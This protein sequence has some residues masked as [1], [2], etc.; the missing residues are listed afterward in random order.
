MAE[1]DTPKV[2]TQAV[3]EFM[4][5]QAINPKMAKQA[6]YKPEEQRVKRKELLREKK[7]QISRTSPKAELTKADVTSAARISRK[8]PRRTAEDMQAQTIAGDVQ[9]VAVEEGAVSRDALVTA[10]QGELTGP[11]AAQTGVAA[12]IDADLA[13]EVGAQEQIAGATAD[14]DFLQS[15]EYRAQ[16]SGFVSDVTGATMQ[17]TPDMTVEGQLARLSEQFNDGQVPSWAAGALRTAN[18]QMA[19]R[20]LG[21]SSMAGAAV[22]Q[23]AME[24]AVPIAVQDSQ[25][26]YKTAV[27]IMNNDQQARLANTQNNL[28]VDL[29]NT[30]NR[31]QM[32]L[33]K[34]QVNASLAGQELSNQQQAN[35]LNAEKFAEAAN[36]TFNFDQQREFANSKMMETMNLQNLSNKQATALAN[37][38]QMSQMDLA[39][40]N[41]RQQAAVQNAQSFMQMDMANLT[42]TQQANVINQAAYQQ[43]MLSDQAAE[44][45]A[46]QFNATSQ[47]QVDQFFANLDQ[48]I[49]KFNAAANNASSQFN[50]GQA[51]ALAQFNNTMKNQR[52]QFNATNKLAVEQ[53]NVQWRREVNTANTAAQNA[54]NQI[55]AA[56]YLNISNTAQN[57][58]WQQFRDE[59]DYAYTAAENANDRSFNMAMAILEADVNRENYQKYLDNETAQAIGDFI[60]RIGISAINA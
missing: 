27:Q 29:A 22:L 10:Q 49:K 51:N 24:A 16:Q 6:V 12:G 53:S 36:I 2:G 1:D 15:D 44:N 55:N 19:A 54:A 47:N 33:A 42:N 59:A 38:A 43:A 20:G 8:D 9:N 25:T 37:A 35:V 21:M 39:N 52:E 17:V 18:Q 11:A 5:Q 32:A 31:Q 58:I 41:A 48:D 7:G 34:L 4:G 23:A 46:A 50:A 30:S 28:N 56:N 57:N 45:A 14:T 40:L 3:D 26:Y 13:R 60:T